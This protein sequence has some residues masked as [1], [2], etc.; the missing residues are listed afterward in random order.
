MARLK[1]A[2]AKAKSA[3][4]RPAGQKQAEEDGTEFRWL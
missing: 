3:G 2:K 4:S 1:E